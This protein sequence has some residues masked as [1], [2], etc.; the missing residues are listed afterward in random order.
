MVDA[1]LDVERLGALLGLAAGSHLFGGRGETGLFLLLV[2]GPVL[3]QELEEGGGWKTSTNPRSDC[4][5]V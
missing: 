2:L 1:V 3:V 4:G 5:N